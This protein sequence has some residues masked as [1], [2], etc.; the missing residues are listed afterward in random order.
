MDSLCVF[1]APPDLVI[2][3][4]MCTRSLDIC[5]KGWR[6]RGEGKGVEFCEITKVCVYF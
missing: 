3:V 6:R 4:F 1:Q 5:W 2:P